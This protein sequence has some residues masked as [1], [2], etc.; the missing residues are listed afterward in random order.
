MKKIAV[1][2]II[3]LTLLLVWVGCLKQSVNA[4]QEDQLGQF[5]VIQY[6]TAHYLGINKYVVFVD[7][8]TNVMYLFV[9]AGD[10]GGV[11][12][13]VNPDGS[14]KL[15]TDSEQADSVVI[16][17]RRPL[18]GLCEASKLYGAE[19]V[20]FTRPRYVPEGFC[21]WCGSEITN[22]RRTSCCCKEC[23]DKF[24]AATSSVM[25][26]NT[27]S[28]SGYRNHIFRRDNYTCQKCGTFHALVNENGIPLPTTDREL[29]LH[30]KTPVSQGGT[31][32]SGNLI[33]WCR[34]CHK[35]WHKEHG[36]EYFESD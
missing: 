33:T 11:T 18:I 7:K 25:Y 14:P 22:K 21:E 30:H 4:S 8:D 1:L 28:A 5:E 29:D 9:D 31:D 20:T 34:T 6:D 15:Y 12:Y 17:K 24:L 2:V 35:T 3:V 27:K 13:M 36:I 16:G 26:V 19:N 32:D 10:N 23:T